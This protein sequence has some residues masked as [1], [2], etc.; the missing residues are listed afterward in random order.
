MNIKRLALWFLIFCSLLVY[1]L[2]FER[3]DTPQHVAILPEETYERVFPFGID[4]ISGVIISNGEK[5][6]R[7]ERH[8]RKMR[9]VEPVGARVSADLRS[10]LLDAI[11]GAVMIDE[12]EA[13]E[14]QDLYG[15]DPPAFI[16]KVYTQANTEPQ[17]LLLGANAPSTVNMYAYLPQ[18]NRTVLLG[19][20][21]RFTLRTFLDN[22]KID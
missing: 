9:L 7:L 3:T 14:Q 2:L 16:V 10:S 20:Y 1:V 21:L 13:G 11:V 18:Q 4:A 19:T 17:T 12:L 5:T 15:L 22:I 8:E 6:V